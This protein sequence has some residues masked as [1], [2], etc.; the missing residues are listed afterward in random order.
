MMVLG[1]LF[2]FVFAVALLAAGIGVFAP[3][4]VK[5]ATRKQALLRYG[6]AAFFSFMLVGVAAFLDKD[7]DKTPVPA[8]EIVE[9]K[10][11]QVKEPVAAAPAK[12]KPE[13]QK[14]FPWVVDDFV[15]R[16]HIFAEAAHEKW[17]VKKIGS[18]R[19]GK[20]L[21]YS[22][23][24]AV[25]VAFEQAKDSE[26]V[27]KATLVIDEY[28][29]VKAKTHESKMALL[30]FLGGVKPGCREG[31]YFKAIDEII[32]DGFLMGGKTLLRDVFLMRLQGPEGTA[33]IVATR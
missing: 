16:V 33:R 19:D 13:V 9:Q 5:C 18:E 11:P 25:G 8:A 21:V 6:G 17:E 2:F 10:M 32:D 4:L 7:T 1:L 27:A 23:G 24:P 22:F 20:F 30:M 12:E 15:E 31:E 29:L 3:R 14:V 28:M 26:Q